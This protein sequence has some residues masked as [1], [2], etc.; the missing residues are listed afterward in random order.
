[1]MFWILLFKSLE[2][3]HRSDGRGSQWRPSHK[4]HAELVELHVAAE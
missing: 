2:S 4:Q 3:L 1:M